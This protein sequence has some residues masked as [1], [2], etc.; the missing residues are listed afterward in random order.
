M[1]ILLIVE[2]LPSEVFDLESA[3]AQALELSLSAAKDDELCAQLDESQDVHG[4][5]LRAM[6]TL[7]GK[8]DKFLGGAT[9]LSVVVAKQGRCL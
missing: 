3:S 4:L 7:E 6:P 9:S 5:E 2:C 8:A 1:V